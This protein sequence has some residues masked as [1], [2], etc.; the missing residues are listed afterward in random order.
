VGR[1][2]RRGLDLLDRRVLELCGRSEGTVD[3][4]VELC[5]RDVDALFLGEVCACARTRPRGLA[6][7]LGERL[8]HGDILFGCDARKGL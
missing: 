2:L 3:S 6:L 1:A 8:V 4:R 5:L 7:F